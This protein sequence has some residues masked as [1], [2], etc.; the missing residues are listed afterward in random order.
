MDELFKML[1]GAV[2]SGVVTR[3]VTFQMYLEV[4]VGFK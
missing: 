3:S 4:G 2:V 1:R